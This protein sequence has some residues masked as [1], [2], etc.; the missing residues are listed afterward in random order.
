MIQKN[1]KTFGKVDRLMCHDM[2]VRAIGTD[3]VSLEC[4]PSLIT[5]KWE[6]ILLEMTKCEFRTI[7][8]KFLFLLDIQQK[9]NKTQNQTTVDYGIF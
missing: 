5:E 8:N 7:K 3:T 9:P 6:D 1:K 2:R 4:P